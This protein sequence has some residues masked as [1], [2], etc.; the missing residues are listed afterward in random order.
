[1]R[2][3]TRSVSVGRMSAW[4]SVPRAKTWVRRGV[5]QPANGL[6]R[7]LATSDGNLD[8]DAQDHHYP[9]PEGSMVHHRILHGTPVGGIPGRRPHFRAMIANKLLLGKRLARQWP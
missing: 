9:R 4:C 7:L 5:G 8:A 6:A 2:S 1:M 3:R